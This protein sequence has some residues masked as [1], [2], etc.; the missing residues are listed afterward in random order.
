M[1]GAG[2]K[3]TFDVIDFQTYYVQV[4]PQALSSG[5]YSLTIR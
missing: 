4:W 2:L 5:R 3:H 1:P